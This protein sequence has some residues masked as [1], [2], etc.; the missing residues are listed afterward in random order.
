MRGLAAALLLATVPA[1]AAEVAGVRVPESLVVD[2]VPLQLNGAGIRTRAVLADRHGH[3][4]SASSPI[5]VD[6][7]IY[8]GALYL[9]KKMSDAAAIVA[10][11]QPKCMR[12]TYLRRVPRSK[13]LGGLK[14]GFE[15]NSK[16]EL[17]EVLPK[18]KLLEQALPDEVQE[19]QVLSVT[20]VPGKGS[21]VAVGGGEPATVA[22]KA[23]SDALFRNWLGP[24]PAD[25]GLKGLKEAILAK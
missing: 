8:V 16:D 7:K 9:P 23:F 19:G 11:D 25:D 13:I 15:S 14:E 18:L 4:P 22:G 1:L 21:I 5:L 17:A 3:A 10:L 2:G 20:Y 6:V 24:R 12:M